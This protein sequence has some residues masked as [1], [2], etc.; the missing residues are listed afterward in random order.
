MGSSPVRQ[1]TELKQIIIQCF[2]AAVSSRRHKVYSAPFASAE[3]VEWILFKKINS[4]SC[5]LLLHFHHVKL[6]I[7]YIYLNIEITLVFLKE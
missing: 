2:K 4:K 5:S 1:F 6:F 3:N 7:V